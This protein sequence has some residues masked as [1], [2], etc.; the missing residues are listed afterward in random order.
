MTWGSHAESCL[1]FTKKW[2][3]GHRE[4][5][6]KWSLLREWR[7]NRVPKQ[8]PEWIPEEELKQRDFIL[9]ER[10]LVQACSHEGLA[11]C[12]CSPHGGWG[13]C[14]ML[15]ECSYF[16]N[17]GM[18]TKVLRLSLSKSFGP[19]RPLSSYWH[20]VSLDKALVA[21]FVLGG[22][23]S[24]SCSF[25]LLSEHFSD[26]WVAAELLCLHLEV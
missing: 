4:E 26:S 22:S 25:S 18:G 16:L 13:G 12:M 23:L 1:W 2:I 11:H 3:L 10:G 21:I 8:D 9:V 7:K 20:A 6:A 14:H 15:Q 17:F 24:H 5:I 19:Q